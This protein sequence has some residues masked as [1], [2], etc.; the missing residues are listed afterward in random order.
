MDEY[1]NACSQGKDAHVTRGRLGE[2][3]NKGSSN[4]EVNAKG[5]R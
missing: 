3:T 1:C 4:N 5:E 2:S